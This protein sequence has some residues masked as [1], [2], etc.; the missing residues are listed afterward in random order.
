MGESEGEGGR[1]GDDDYISDAKRWRERDERERVTHVDL[2]LL[3]VEFL[4]SDFLF[5]LSFSFGAGSSFLRKAR[6]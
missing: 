6:E 3:D 2:A 1:K 4:L 5:E